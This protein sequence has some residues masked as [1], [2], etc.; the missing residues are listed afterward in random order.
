[1]MPCGFLGLGHSKAVSN[2]PCTRLH[3]PPCEG[4]VP[5]SDPEP[6][7]VPGPAASKAQSASALPAPSLTPTQSCNT[8]NTVSLARNT[9]S[10]ARNT[11]SL[12][13]NTISLA[14]ALDRQFKLPN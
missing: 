14:H 6:R 8:C 5:V 1:M 7:P 3:A 9:V 4:E 13:R 11:V 12:A 10:L 2:L